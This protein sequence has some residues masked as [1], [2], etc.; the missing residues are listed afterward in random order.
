LTALDGRALR[1]VRVVATAPE[2]RGGVARTIGRA[3]TRRDGLWAMRMRAR[4]P[5]GRVTFTY[6]DGRGDG[7]T[8][9]LRARVSA[10]VALRAKRHVMAAF[11][12]IELA[13]RLL[14]GPV[15]G[16]GKLVEIRARGRG[17]RRWIT[18]KTVRTDRRGRFEASHRLRQGYRNETYEFQA[19]SRYEAGY[20]YETGA[21]N[22]ERVAVR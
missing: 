12:R 13:G 3:T 6:A 21:S 15:P 17:E 8:A 1:G 22:V 2:R 19:V 9:T 18:F 14:G 5:S 11:G 4:F 20:R 16:R 10:G 7:A